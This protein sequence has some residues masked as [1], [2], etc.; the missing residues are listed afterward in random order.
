M[1]LYFVVQPATGAVVG[2]RFNTATDAPLGL[3]PGAALIEIDEGDPLASLHPSALYVN[4]AGAHVRE[5]PPIT[6]SATGIAADGVAEAVISGIPAGSVLTITGATEVD[7]ATIDDGEVV[8]TST[9]VGRLNVR[10]DCPA[11]YLRWEAAVDAT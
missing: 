6:L 11:P 4:E 7:P 8:L 9:A 3:P 5:D 2:R 1:P 10:L